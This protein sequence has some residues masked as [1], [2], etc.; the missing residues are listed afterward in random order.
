MIDT[1]HIYTYIYVSVPIFGGITWLSWGPQEPHSASG[2]DT[3]KLPGK[4]VA[5]EISGG[6]RTW[7]LCSDCVLRLQGIASSPALDVLFF[8][9]M[10]RRGLGSASEPDSNFEAGRTVNPH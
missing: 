6:K 10:A 5:V 7:K 1:R 3:G 2:E 8:F 9:F 4:V